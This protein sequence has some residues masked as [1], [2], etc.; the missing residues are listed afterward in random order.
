MAL[1]DEGAS[2]SNSSFSST[3][4]WKFH[5]FLSF[6]GADT[7]T[8]FTDYLYAT[9]QRKGIITFRDDEQLEKG[10]VI[11][12]QLLKAI[13]ESLSTIVVLSRQYASSSWCLDSNVENCWV[14]KLSQSSIMLTPQKL[15][16]KREVLAKHLRN[17]N[18][19]MKKTRLKDGEMP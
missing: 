2:S 19:D 12:Q 3:P 11:S 13:E 9:L 14:E 17:M 6:R 18:K 1:G 16:I 15:G 7:R 8:S 4:Q 5:V 10:E